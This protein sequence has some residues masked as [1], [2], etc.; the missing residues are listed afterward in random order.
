MDPREDKAREWFSCLRS[1]FYVPSVL[2]TVG[3]MIGGAS[4]L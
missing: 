1:V 2:D 4:S 3:W